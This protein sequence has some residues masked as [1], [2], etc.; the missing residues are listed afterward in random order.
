MIGVFDSGYGGLTVIRALSEGLPEQSF[1]YLGDHAAAPYGGRRNEEILELTREAS[2]RL[3]RMGCRLVILACNTASA[4]ALRRLQQEWLP[5]AYPDRRLLGCVVPVVEAITRQPWQVDGP[6]AS[7]PREPEA[8]AVFAT[9][10]T[11]D[12]AAYPREIAKR[13][14]SV[15]VVQQACPRLAARI[16]EGA[17]RRMLKRMVRDQVA[18]LRGQMGSV[19][20]D[21]VVLGCT[22]YPLVAEEFRAALPARV[23]ILDQPALVARSLAAYLRRHPEFDTTEARGPSGQGDLCFRTTGATEHVS[24]LG[25]RFFGRDIVFEADRELV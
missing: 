2:E 8:V 20:P 17:P 5:G 6:C 14:P 21:T 1:L 16:E 10:R 12:S 13:A 18:A 11:V 22:H 7:A 23:E 15:T 4:V 9:R 3:F 24:R 19:L 25:S